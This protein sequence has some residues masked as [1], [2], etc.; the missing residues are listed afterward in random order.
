MT[1]SGPA[2][3][4]GPQFQP[5]PASG[6]GHDATRLY[7]IA[8]GALAVVALVVVLIVSQSGGGGDDDDQATP[9]GPGQATTKLPPED[10]TTTTTVDDSGGTITGDPGAPTPDP[11]PGDDWN[12][13]A[14]AQF[15]GDCAT[16]IASQAGL[17]G[18]DADTMCLCV[19]DTSEASGVTFADF[20]EAWTADELDTSQGAGA[21]IYGAMATCAFEIMDGA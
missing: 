6:G 1:Q 15:A 10:T 7:L 18:D 19:Y 12:G 2:T 8:V 13:D 17:F 3:Y 11:L 14:R 9:G 21:E 4:A 5:Q 20:N 16:G